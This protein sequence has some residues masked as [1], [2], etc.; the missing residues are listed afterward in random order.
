MS[1]KELHNKLAGEIVKSIVKPIVETGGSEVQILVLLESVI[2]GVILF[3]TPWPGTDEVV[4]DKLTE[5]VKE[6]LV[7]IRLGRKGDA[8]G[9]HEI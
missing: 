1:Q 2:T 5:G 8:D 4:L 6:R 3:T 7:E 9:I